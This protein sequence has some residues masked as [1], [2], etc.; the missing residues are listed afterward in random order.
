MHIS[1]VGGTGSVGAL[2][3]RNLLNAG[4]NITAIGSGQSQHYTHII[5][6]GL[7]IKDSE[8]VS[9]IPADKFSSRLSQD[10]LQDLVIVS[11]KQPNL[12]TML[13]QDILGSIANNSI[14]A[15]NSNGLPFYFLN[16]LNISGKTHLQSV[17]PNGNLQKATSHHCIV[18]V[19]PI[20]AACIPEPGTVEITRPIAKISITVGIHKNNDNC[21]INKVKH[22]VNILHHTGLN[23]YFTEYN[24][25][26]EIIKKEQFALSILTQSALFNK[27]LGEIY[28]GAIYQL[29]I[30]YSATLV[31]NISLLLKIGGLRSYE[32]IKA[33]PI[34]KDHYASLAKDINEAKTSEIN[35][36][37]GTIIEL[38]DYF[39]IT[40][41]SPIKMIQDLLLQRIEGYVITVD[42]TKTL[43]E[44]SEQCLVE[45]TTTVGNQYSSHD[46]L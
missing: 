41:I 36:I 25:H 12:N 13:M 40:C 39:N 28:D 4:Q 42:Q 16:N 27:T 1:I 30:R 18:G 29:F 17:D 5:S 31:N 46:E 22:F 43:Q 2:F 15:V 19:V 38:A 24:L 9:L 32:E 35:A 3:T 7:K 14:I 26:L 11:V 45:I 33:I 23:T 20:I 34:T 6:H 44:S 10:H 37:V 21:D 8:G